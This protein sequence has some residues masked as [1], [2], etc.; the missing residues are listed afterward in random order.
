M[1]FEDDPKKDFLSDFRCRVG[2]RF[3]QAIEMTMAYVFRLALQHTQR[4]LYTL[5]LI[6]HE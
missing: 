1:L 6:R 5:K 2:D 4:T 3:E